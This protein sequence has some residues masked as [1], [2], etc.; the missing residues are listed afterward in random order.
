MYMQYIQYIYYKYI[1]LRYKN[2]I[3]SKKNQYA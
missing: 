1:E 2:V 3:K